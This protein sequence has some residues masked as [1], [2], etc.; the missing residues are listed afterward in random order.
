ML[1]AKRLLCLL[2][3]LLMLQTSMLSVAQ[4]NNEDFCV[5]FSVTE[6]NGVFCE[7]YLI[8]RGIPIG[9]NILRD[10]E[11]LEVFS[12]DKNAVIPSHTKVLETYESG[13]AKWVL[14]AIAQDI[15]PYETQNYILR[16]GKGVK[17]DV[18]KVEEVPGGSVSVDNGVCS[19]KIGTLGINSI[20]YNG[21]NI[22]DEKG[23]V[24]YSEEYEKEKRLNSGGSI[25]IV[26]NNDIYTEIKVLQ[27]FDNDAIMRIEKVF[28]ITANS[29]IIHC[30]TRN[31]SHMGSITYD[32]NN[33][34]MDTINS[35]YDKY[36][37]NDAFD[38]FSYSDESLKRKSNPIYSCDYVKL[39]DTESATGVAIV[40]K[41]VQKF[42]G[43]VTPLPDICNGFYYDNEQNSLIFAPILYK[44]AYTKWIDGTSK[45]THNEIIL[46]RDRGKTFD[47]IVKTR[48]N[49]PWVSIDKKQFI[50][51]GL[52]KTTDISA[53]AQ[54][55]LD[56]IK[57]HRN[58]KVYGKW[59]AGIVPY[60]INSY[61]GTCSGEE[62]MLG[63]ITYN[64][65][66][67][68][69]VSGDGT[70]FD[71]ADE[72]TESW[73]DNS[74][75][76][77]RVSDA[78]GA[79]R[80]NYNKLNPANHPF[81]NEFSNC[82][83]GYLMTGN[84]YYKDTCKLMA[85]FFY[86]T[87]HLSKFGNGF[88]IALGSSW[89][90]NM[91]EP[92]QYD[93]TRFNYSI[94]AMQNSYNLFKDEDYAFVAKSI[95]DWLAFC[96][97]PEGFWYQF[98][99]RDGNYFDLMKTPQPLCKDYIML[100]SA[101]GYKD[102]YDMTKDPVMKETLIKFGDYLIREMGDR[103]WMYSPCSDPQICETGED[104]SRGKSPMQEI[105]AAEIFEMLY[106]ETGDVKYFKAFCT[107]I[108]SYYSSCYKNGLAV[109]HFNEPQYADG[110]M[111]AVNGGQ[112]LNIM[113]MDNV[114]TKLIKDN[115]KLVHKLGFDDLLIALAPGSKYVKEGIFSLHDDKEV[116]TTLIEAPDGKRVFFMGN[117][118]GKESGEWKK[119][120]KVH[121]E[122]AKIWTNTTTQINSKLEAVVGHEMEYFDY[123]SCLEL[124]LELTK[125][126][127]TGITF[128]DTVMTDEKISFNA[129]ADNGEYVFLIEDKEYNTVNV[130]GDKVKTVTITKGEGND[131]K[132][133]LNFSS[134]NIS[135]IENHW[136][137]DDALILINSGILKGNTDG[138]IRPEDNVT[139]N[140]L[141]LLVMRS[142]GYSD[143]EAVNKAAE[144]GIV[145]KSDLNN[146]NENVSR[147]KATDI[148][149]KALSLKI[150]EKKMP[151]KVNEF[152]L[153]RKIYNDKEAVMLDTQNLSFEST[154]IYEDMILPCEGLY[155]SNI[156][157]QS[158]DEEC[159]SPNGMV[160]L[161]IDEDKKVTLTATIERNGEVETRSFDFTVKAASNVLW[162]AFEGFSDIHKTNTIQNEEKA[163]SVIA[164]PGDDIVDIV[165]GFASSEN[166]TASYG[167]LNLKWRFNSSGYIDAHNA[168]AYQAVDS[169]RYEKNKKYR[170]DVKVRLKDKTYDLTVTDEDGNTKVIAKNYVFSTN[171]PSMTKLDEF[172]F[173]ATDV[174]G[175]DSKA[176]ITQFDVAYAGTQGKYGL[177]SASDYWNIQK[178]D[179][180]I[181]K[182]SGYNYYSS[183]ENIITGDGKYL[184]NPSENKKV[185]IIATLN[186]KPL[187]K[188]LREI[189]DECFVSSVKA[190]YIG[191]VNGDTEG[192]LHPKDILKRAECIKMVNNLR[193][194]TVHFD[195]MFPR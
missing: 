23:V 129:S 91:F 4:A 190:K 66:F 76:R 193:Q 187:F 49:T 156:T 125:I 99:D 27:E 165:F 63:E 124:P 72:G 34:C 41:D 127:G 97:E 64:T 26:E 121:I 71:A 70:V 104:D 58:N 140:E 32:D 92:N 48:I 100:Y 133:I 169:V 18:M 132:L 114:Y 151:V 162:N 93:E 150:N 166:I 185:F 102:Y 173:V 13:Y 84:N 186:N 174:S 134:E 117:N 128:T 178:S 25:Q 192:Y 78:R 30:E 39:Y 194:L 142:I 191:L 10:A 87:S 51:A 96:Q 31:V 28:T 108:R 148:L 181:E 138:T 111:N 139:L 86:R 107:A 183:D 55:Q 177:L 109:M 116:T 85:D 33:T 126:S 168:T 131:N 65:W 59:L 170:F 11:N 149:Y 90:Y 15:K 54:L 153:V 53:M 80:S 60:S 43:G 16:T 94:R 69:M 17:S 6:Q 101:R 83:I 3:G 154:D 38:S 74:V 122:D 182:E 75:Y 1:K 146:L 143:M 112:V 36:Y 67:G 141:L 115:E 81:Y 158:S 147:E 8:K 105:M 135:D 40:S 68:A 164:S 136:V 103:G 155:E 152:N 79:A 35:L 144:L 44:K 145:T 61:R 57:W 180:I 98:Y 14:V 73:S 163:F 50:D 113:R 195:T 52:I 160:N 20:I 47:D 7:K 137:R 45:T 159:I 5:S 167:G 110:I 56:E 161:P 179:V 62:V 37:F 22:F 21:I 77:G 29:P 89:R 123:A 171:A 176:V 82:Y 106:R 120:L 9:D 172:Y 2:L 189:S 130:S 42:R 118:S 88:H 184:K 119:T 175:K 95:S 188:D 24:S 19:V 157:W 12:V 46:Y